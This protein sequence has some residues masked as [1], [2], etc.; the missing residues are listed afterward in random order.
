MYGWEKPFSKIVSV[1]RKL[2]I[3]MIKFSSY[4]R[5]AYLAIIVFTERLIL[6]FTLI[7]FV[8]TGNDLTADVTYEMAT[9]FNL[10]QLTAAL[11]FPQALIQLG[12]S[13]VSMYRLEVYRLLFLNSLRT[14][15]IPLFQNLSNR[16][17]IVPKF[18]D[19][20]IRND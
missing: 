16:L 14:L 3:N 4:V 15:S 10:L 11:Y 12:E 8:L 7:I 5:A 19:C 20:H 2:E 9:Y 17:S 1:T 13:M 18:F 6:Y